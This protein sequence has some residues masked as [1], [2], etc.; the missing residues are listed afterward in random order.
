V[1]MPVGVGQPFGGIEDGDGATFVAV[2]AFVAAVGRPERGRGGGDL[3][4]TLVQRWLV[5]LDLDD[6]GDVGLCGA[7]MAAKD[8]L[9]GGGIQTLEDVTDR[10]VRGCAPPFRPKAVFSL[11]RCTS[12]KVTMPR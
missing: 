2:S 5:V 7:G 6:Q 12:M 3:V 9:D 1:G 4:A 10:G 8:R 11:R